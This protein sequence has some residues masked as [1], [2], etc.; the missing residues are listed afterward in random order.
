[1]YDTWTNGT[2]FLKRRIKP[3]SA[4]ADVKKNNLEEQATH[5]MFLIKVYLI[6]GKAQL[7]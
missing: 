6:L 5:R 7:R 1:M 3:T 2:L 4:E